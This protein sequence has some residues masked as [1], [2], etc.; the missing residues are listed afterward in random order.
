MVCVSI[1]NST[2]RITKIHVVLQLTD[3]VSPTLLTIMPVC[4]CINTEIT[5]VAITKILKSLCT[6]YVNGNWENFDCF[7]VDSFESTKNLDCLDSVVHTNVFIRSDIEAASS[8]I[9]CSSARDNVGR[10]LALCHLGYIDSYRSKL[11][12][13]DENHWKQCHPSMVILVL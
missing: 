5:T 8:Y 7:P 11:F 1:I 13:T 10:L 4:L 12:N 2:K 9:C 3:G 6:W